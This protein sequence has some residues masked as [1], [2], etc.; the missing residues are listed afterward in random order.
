MPNKYYVIPDIHGRKD[1]LDLAFA[2]LTELEPNGGKIIFLGDYID[3]GKQSIEV[4]EAVMNPMEGW[5]HIPLVGNHED[6]FVDS[7]WDKRKYPF[8]DPNVVK[9]LN[10]PQIKKY[11][12]WM[13][14][15]KI[16][17]IE[18]ENIFAHAF[19]DHTL[20]EQTKSVCI[21]TR[22]D[23]HQ[24]F[25]HPEGF[26][27]THGHTPRKNGPILAPNRTN[28]DCG[29]VFYNRLVI[30]VYE[31]NVKGPIDFIEITI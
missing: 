21:W 16:F 30:G 5:T 10:W 22:L 1:L 15:L 6:M 26:H 18:D 8:C 19:Y 23:D 7:A 13:S 4:V 9:N 14:K 11:A 27:L 17:H 31:Q 29:A 2:K 24:S 28:L 20:T 12:A 25:F 3:R